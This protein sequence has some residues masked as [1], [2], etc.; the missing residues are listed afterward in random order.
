MNVVIRGFG[1]LGNQLFQYAAGKYYAKRY[2][3]ALRIAVDPAWN[4]Q[5]NGYPRPCLLSHFSITAP[6]AERSISDR[7]LLTDK[8]WLK[9]AAAPFKSALQIQVFTEQ[10][11][12]RYCFLRDLSLERDVR[13]LYLLG[14][15]QANRLVEEIAGRT[16]GGF[17]SQGASTGE[18][19]GATATDQAK[20]ES[21]ITPYPPRRR[22]TSHGRQG[23]F[24][25]GVLFPRHL[26]YQGTAH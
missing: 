7:I 16:A 4:A 22:H 5:C 21:G 12:H 24:A 25:N 14:Y 18:E 9:A 15:F 23:R 17:D 6:L 2:G 10:P 8:A 13:T 19:S 26:H 3:A 20:Q 11:E 1:G